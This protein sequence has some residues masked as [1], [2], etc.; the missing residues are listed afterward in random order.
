MGKAIARAS[1]LTE[2]LCNIVESLEALCIPT[3]VP[4]RAR[5]TVDCYQLHK[6]EIENK[7]GAI[8]SV[9]L[10]DCIEGNLDKVKNELIKLGGAKY[11][12]YYP[13]HLIP[14]YSR[15]GIIY[16]WILDKAKEWKKS[17]EVEKKRGA[18]TWTKINLEDD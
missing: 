4:A 7:N 11:W 2:E 3:T 1:T 13:K 6:R 10:K 17:I 12:N 18:I 15:T 16:I 9:E 14:T 5:C 8:G